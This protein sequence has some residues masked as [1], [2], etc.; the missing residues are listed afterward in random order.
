MNQHRS[1]FL[2]SI[3]PVVKN[4]LVINLLFW[5]AAITLHQMKGIN[6]N[7]WLGL[8]Y[9]EASNFYPFQFITYMFLHSLDSFGHLFFNMFGLFMFGRILEY[10]WGSKRFLVYYM[11]TG[12]GAGIIQQVAWTVDLHAV[13][14]EI[15]ELAASGVQQ[16]VNVGDR[17]IYSAEELLRWKG[18]VLFN[19]LITVGA[20]GSIFGLLLAFGMLFP[21]QPLFIMFIPVP[22]KAKYFVIGYAV[23]ELFLGVGNFQFDNVAHFAH[24][25]GMLFGY[26]LIRKW[27]RNASNN[28]TF[29]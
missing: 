12:I 24:L 25:G 9:W 22:V 6:V 3:P 14:K 1:S 23:I 28:Q 11:I 10:T 29:G 5:L 16:G 26:F 17:I 13:S 7:Y 4:L 15:A 18:E 27:K 8:H 20:S 21:N 19:R 2:D